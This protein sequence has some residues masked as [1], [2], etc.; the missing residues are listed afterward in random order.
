MVDESEIL[1]VEEAASLLK[2]SKKAI[3]HRVDRKTI[4]H[5]RLG[6]S[7]RFL[8]SD[9]DAWLKEHTVQPKAS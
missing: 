4:P 3:Y 8:R 5:V 1:T 2:M 6:G 9:L 7:L